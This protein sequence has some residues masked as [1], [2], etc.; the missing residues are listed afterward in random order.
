MMDMNKLRLWLGAE[1]CRAQISTG[2][3]LPAAK[4][5]AG[6]ILPIDV[7]WFW[8]DDPEAFSGRRWIAVAVR[9]ACPIWWWVP[10]QTAN[11]L[12]S[13]DGKWYIYVFS[14]KRKYEVPVPAVARQSASL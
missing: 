12:T 11:R 5:R 7:W 8:D 1:H 6:K 3:S 2:D 9:R 13:Y 14:G 4:L 10:S